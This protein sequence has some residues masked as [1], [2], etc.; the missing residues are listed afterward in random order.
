LLDPLG[1]SVAS[2]LSVAPSESRASAL[3]WAAVASCFAAG[4]LVGRHRRQRRLLAAGLAAAALF[5]VVYGASTLGTGF[6]WGVDVLHDPSRLRGT[7]VNPNH[8]AMY[9][10][11]AL[12]AN[13]AWG[14]WAVR[15]F[16]MEASIE[17]RA[18]WIIPPVLLW[19][20]LFTGLA[21][22]GSRAG[23]LA[24]LAGVCVQGFLVAR[25]LRSWRVGL[26][27]AA[28]MLLGLGVVVA[29]GLQQG[30]GRWMGTSP[31]DLSWNHRLTVYKA[32]LGLWWEFPWIG[33][34]L[35][36]FQEAFT[37]VQPA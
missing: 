10:E 21:F 9:L 4:A 23:L 17:R 14:W 34:G 37:M 15:R 20:I 35:G 30:L 25:T 8:L 11:I 31:Y 33:T 12:A 24:A 13:F 1:L 28:A 2:T 27:G 6:I 18:L 29:I 32:T 22:S 26:L 7:F 3:L 16:R 5:Q 19:L 36:T